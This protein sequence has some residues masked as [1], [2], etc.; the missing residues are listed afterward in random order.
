MKIKKKKKQEEEEIKNTFKNI[1]SQTLYIDSV[2]QSLYIY[3][4]HKL[5]KKFLFRCKKNKI[6][7]KISNFGSL[8]LERKP[9]RDKMPKAKR[10]LSSRGD[11]IV[12]PTNSSVCRRGP[13]CQNLIS[14]HDHDDEHRRRT[15]TS[16]ATLSL[17]LWLFQFCYTVTCSNT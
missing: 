13:F 10:R 4:F 16:L 3:K 2:Y 15:C 14:P 5:K 17:S 6:K 7:F 8:I 11:L 9:S 12:A 1:F